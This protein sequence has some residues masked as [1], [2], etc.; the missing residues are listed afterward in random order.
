MKK[1][2]IATAVLSI[3]TVFNIAY[4]NNDYPSKPISLIVPLG[5]GGAT[6]VVA[7]V[8]A[9]KL[10]EQLGQAVVVENRPGAEGAIGV[11]AGANA[12][13]DGYTYVLGSSSTVAANYYLRN[14]LPYHPKNDLTPVATAL[15]DFFNVMVINPDIPANNLN[16]FIELAKAEP[17]KYNYGAATSGAKICTESFKTMAGIDLQMINYK[18]SPQALNDLIGGRLDI[19]CEPVATA[20]PHIEAGRLKS[21]GVTSPERVENAPDLVTVSES[22]LPDFSFSAWVAVFAPANTPKSVIDTFSSAL[23]VVL[24]DPETEE[25]IKSINAAPMI[26]GSEALEELLDS[27]MKR[28]EKIVRDANIM[29]E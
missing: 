25:R 16:E 9:E 27:E 4:A 17:G 23:E 21:I 13:P 20:L 26:G 8:M 15:K 12:N 3:S 19:I 11:L 29:P 1:S 24:S 5:A 22:G 7:R 14:D 6:D 18:S 10:G 2:L 28:A